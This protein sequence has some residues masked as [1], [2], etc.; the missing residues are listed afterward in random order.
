MK[1]LAGEPLGAT[2]NPQ[3]DPSLGAKDLHILATIYVTESIFI[4]LISRSLNLKK[5]YVPLFIKLDTIDL[6]K[7]AIKF[8]I[9]GV[10]AVET[11]Q[12]LYLAGKLTI[13]KMNVVR[14]YLEIISKHCKGIDFDMTFYR[15]GQQLGLELTT[16]WAKLATCNYKLVQDER[17]QAVRD[18]V[19]G[20][21]IGLNRINIDIAVSRKEEIVSILKEI[22]QGDK[23]DD[24]I[25]IVTCD[26]PP[27]FELH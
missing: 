2:T 19:Y 23:F 27:R 17:L 8:N 13:K 24:T 6:L 3:R 21:G 11:F 26:E 14:S 18:D 16:D 12:W 1:T 4:N 25:T 7:T 10:E 15:V 20:I 22:I 5:V 9:I